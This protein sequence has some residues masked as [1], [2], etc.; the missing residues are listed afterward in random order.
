MDEYTCAKKRV[1]DLETRMDTC[2]RDIRHALKNLDHDAFETARFE[3]DIVAKDLQKSRLRLER[4]EK[5]LGTEFRENRP[6]PP[7]SHPIDIN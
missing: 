2:R 4:L 7:E 5:R 6:D 3:A 1:D